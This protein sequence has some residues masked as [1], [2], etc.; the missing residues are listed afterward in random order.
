MAVMAL[1]SGC[2]RNEEKKDNETPQTVT[3]DLMFESY[4]YDM[5]GE[6]E[7][8]DSTLEPGAGYI[9]FTSQGV[10]PQLMGDSDSGTVKLRDSLMYLAGITTDEIGKPVPMLP[11]S[12]VMVEAIPD[13]IGDTGYVN[14]KLTATLVTPRVVVW[15]AYKEGY[16]WLAAHGN[17][18]AS[19]VN[20]CLTD[21]RILKI[22]D[23]LKPGYES[24][25]LRLIKNKVKEQNVQLLGNFSDIEIPDQFAI[26]SNGLL[27]SYDPYV[28]AP[29][30]EGIIS[31]ELPLAEIRPL[32]NP[33]GIFIF[34]GE[35]EAQKPL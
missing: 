1:I 2:S 13:T 14:S 29:Y 19:Y 33:H 15:E 4:V 11:D 24:R 16:P 3:K 22:K 18:S 6:F 31:I 21:N 17:K 34:T 7:N 28:I 12:M 32:L 5:A 20:Y 27:F 8:L 26:T 9:R 10:L 35:S 23:I 30:S 25:L